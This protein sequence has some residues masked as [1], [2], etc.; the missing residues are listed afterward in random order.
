MQPSSL[1]NS[2]KRRTELAV[3]SV[4]AFKL[5]AML[6]GSLYAKFRYRLR[7]KPQLVTRFSSVIRSIS[8]TGGERDIDLF[9]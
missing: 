3:G 8:F 7:L 1:W 4:V 5:P 6:Q 9:Q 2:A